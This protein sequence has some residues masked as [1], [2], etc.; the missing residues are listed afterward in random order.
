[1]AHYDYDNW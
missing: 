1:C